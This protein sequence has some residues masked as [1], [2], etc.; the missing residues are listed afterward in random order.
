VAAVVTRGGRE[1]PL[2]LTPRPM[3][4][5][6]IGVTPAKFAMVGKVAEDGPAKAAGIQPGDEILS[7]NGTPTPTFD[8]VW[9]IV[10][11]NLGR[12]VKYAVRR[13]GETLELTLT[14]TPIGIGSERGT[15]GIVPAK[16]SDFTVGAVKPGSPA[17]TAGI[18]PG[19]VLTRVGGVS[20]DKKTWDHVQAIL[21]LAAAGDGKVSIARRRGK[22]EFAAVEVKVKAVDDPR[23][24]EEGY[25]VE[26]GEAKLYRYSPWNAPI[27]GLKKAYRTVRLIFGSVRGM[28]QG[29]ISP[30]NMAGPVGIFRI[31]F[32]VTAA[33]VTTLVYWLAFLSANFAVVNLLPMPP[34][35]GGLLVYS[36]IEKVRGKPLSDRILMVAQTIGWALVIV[37]MVL[38]TIND[39]RR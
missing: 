31:G 9:T 12:P 20:I 15:D 28:I 19:D 17:E 23:H 38:I 7:V 8:D 2:T 3:K 21:D 35:D 14:P 26:N 34:F 11:A 37:L 24:A 18:Q 10:S 4:R 32:A 1:Q 30:D 22:A 6:A 27:V 29:R 16:A 39:I 13:G 36:A 33:G 25:A 5:G